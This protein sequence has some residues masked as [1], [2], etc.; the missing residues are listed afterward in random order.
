[1][2]TK[3]GTQSLSV[4]DPELASQAHGWDPKTVTAGSSLKKEW[5][6]ERD[7]V[8][9][10][11]I[12]DRTRGRGCPICSGRK[13]L[14]GFNDLAT[15]NPELASQAHGWDPKTVTAGSSSKKE[16]ICERDHV[17]EALIANRTNGTDCP[18]CNGKKV[19]IGFNDLATLN[20]ELA[21][22]AYGWD[23]ATVT[24]S[25]GLKR[26]WMC[27]LGHIWE[28]SI[29]SR[30]IGKG[31]SI[32]NG[33][34]ASAGFN[35][36]A[37]LN[38]ELASQA[39]G[40]DPATV[41]RSSGLKRKWMCQLGHIW[42]ASIDHR[43]AGSGCSVCNGNQVS[44]GFN[45]LATLNPELA[46][47]AYGWDPATVTTG[48]GLKK[49]WMCALGHFWSAAVH[50]RVGGGGCPT[51]NGKKVLIG[52]NDLATLD[53]ELASQAYGWDPATVTRSSSLKKMWVCNYG[54]AWPASPANR[55]KGRGCPTCANYG[56]DPNSDGWLYFLTHPYWQMLQIGIT[57]FPD[58]R[59]KIH[60]KLGWELIELRGPMDGL[61]ARE[62]ETSILQMLKRSGAKLAA[63]EV[64]GK[65]D[66]YTEAWIT[67]SFAVN[68]LAELMQK[69]Q[70][71]E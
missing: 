19:L 33:Q 46:S 15:L 69:V 10:A 51:C 39:Y 68:S 62:W 16:W 56:F 21:S 7:H 53:P 57:N 18:I 17:W 25:S 43:R 23:P 35:D 58:E 52:F 61:I 42:E 45:D 24:R 70:D 48:S 1:V 3:K 41:T 50:S 9:E 4:T 27:Q 67:E 32:C 30:A 26:K 22:Q 31:C 54:H 37:T 66:G 11:I 6:C 28:A 14:I 13:V 12:A 63:E 49:K 55:T 59:L 2:P 8:W 65:F 34:R 29:A 60:E 64:A 44:I 71:D 47:Q 5:I 36:L 38:P 40:W 20:P